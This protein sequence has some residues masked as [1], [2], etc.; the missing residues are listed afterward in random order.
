MP[1]CM[2]MTWASIHIPEPL[3]MSTRI[4]SMKDPLLERVYMMWIYLA[5]RSMTVSLKTGFSVTICWKDVIRRNGWVRADCQ[6]AS[7]F[8]PFV[9]GARKRLQ[10]NPLAGVSRWIIFDKLRRSLVTDVLLV[11]LILGWTILKGAWFWTLSSLAFV[12][13]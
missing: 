12:F 3:Q 6:I 7:W 5:E 2:E 1:A 11:L 8:L 9:P 10:K 13:L 4:Y